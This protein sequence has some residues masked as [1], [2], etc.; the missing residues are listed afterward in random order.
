MKI[1]FVGEGM[2][3]KLS[4]AGEGAEW[5]YTHSP[6]G[7]DQLNHALT[8]LIIMGQIKKNFQICSI[9]IRGDCIGQK[10]ISR[11]HS[12]KYVICKQYF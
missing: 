2:Q 12:F 6:K 7:P 5:K 11:Y 1:G 8:R 9:Q 3:V 4:T 10:T